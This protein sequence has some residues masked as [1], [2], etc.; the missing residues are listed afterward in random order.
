MEIDVENV[1]VYVHI[2]KINGKMYCGQT[3]DAAYRWSNHG[4]KYKDSP[5]F[6]NAIQ[7]YGWDAFDHLIVVDNLNREMANIVETEIIKKYN[8]CD[9]RFGYNLAVGGGNASKPIKDLTGQIF[10]RLTVLEFDKNRQGNYWIC[11][12]SC[13][14]FVSVYSHSLLSGATRSCGCYRD[15]VSKN[16]VREKSPYTKRQ[17]K[18]IYDV[19]RC[20]RIKEELCADWLD[21]KQFLKW[22]VKNHLDTETAVIRINNEEKYSPDNCK[23]I[24][25]ET[26]RRNAKAKKYECDGEE[27]TIFEAS[28]RSGI[29]EEAL[30]SRINDGL[31]IKEAMEK[32]Y[33]Y[34]IGKN[35]RMVKNNQYV[36]NEDGAMICTN[37]GSFKVDLEDFE[38]IKIYNWCIDSN[39]NITTR[40]N[41]KVIRLESI[42]FDIPRL[43]VAKT[44]FI[45]LNDDRRDFRKK[46]CSLEIIDNNPQYRYFIH[47]VEAN[48]ITY[49]RQ[50]H[51][52]RVGKKNDVRHSFYNLED[53]LLEYDQRYGTDLLSPFLIHKGE[54][55]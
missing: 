50:W 2:N 26:F 21:F 35:G 40:T 6:W 31:S 37:T 8:L 51:K 7:K 34:G 46:N 19:W 49:D 53:A 1:C 4:L 9:D 24:P 45:F 12:C 17:N 18:R 29:P 54:M 22:A 30:R 23:V 13:G 48:G 5:K 55:N 38:N 28:Q 20:I 14:N 11:Q 44:N 16:R 36:F 3:N 39:G 15:D 27:L 32:P 47:N 41:D 43:N 42:L 10:G 33:K 52:W 25:R